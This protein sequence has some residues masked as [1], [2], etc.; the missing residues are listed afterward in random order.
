[1]V[2]GYQDDAGPVRAHP[3]RYLLRRE[4]AGGGIA[5]DGE[6]SIRS[7][8]EKGLSGSCRSDRRA[9]RPPGGGLPAFQS[10]A[11][12]REMRGARGSSRGGEGSSER[13]QGSGSS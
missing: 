12:R 6:K 4:K 8:I 11:A 9:C 1:M 7:G 3:K 2:H 13:R 5:Q 10:S